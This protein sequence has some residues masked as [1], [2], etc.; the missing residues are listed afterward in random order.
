M[1]K[2]KIFESFD[3]CFN[4]EA[5]LKFLE[6]LLK[7]DDPVSCSKMILKSAKSQEKCKSS[8][9]KIELAHLFYILMDEGFLFFD[10]VDKKI[11]RNKFQKFVINNFTYCGI[12]GIQINMSSINKQFSECKGYTYKE[13]QVKFLEELITRMQYRKKRLEDW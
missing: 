13:K 10:S 1:K 3:A 11:N 8:Y 7:I 12:Q 5:R 6:N 9:S 2:T 4:L